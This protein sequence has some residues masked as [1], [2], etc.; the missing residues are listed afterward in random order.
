QPH[1][2]TIHFASEKVCFDHAEAVRDREIGTERQGRDADR[3][4]RP[5]RHEK[6]QGQ[7][8]SRHVEDEP[9]GRVS[10]AR[11]TSAYYVEIRE[12]PRVIFCPAFHRLSR[13][14]VSRLHRVEIKMRCGGFLNPADS[15]IEWDYGVAISPATARR[16]LKARI[17]S[18]QKLNIG[19]YP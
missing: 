10:K 12:T 19:E 7:H 3:E 2:Q 9:F 18:A 17:T 13:R 14:P 11:C 5:R 15:L 8:R 1:A 4:V 6:A 16:Y